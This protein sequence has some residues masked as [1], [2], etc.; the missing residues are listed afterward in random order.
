MSFPLLV[1]VQPSLSLEHLLKKPGIAK[2]VPRKLDRISYEC[3]YKSK[4]EILF[5][6][7][8]TDPKLSSNPQVLKI[9]KDLRGGSWEGTVV[10]VF[11][12]VIILI[13]SKGA[14]FVPNNQNLGWG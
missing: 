2:L 5:L 13:L 12:G 10:V 6:L 14:G 11:I 3:F 1:R 4:E 9:I 8:A 7:Y